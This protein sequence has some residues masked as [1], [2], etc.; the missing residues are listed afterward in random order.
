MIKYVH[1]YISGTT[2]YRNLKLWS[3]RAFLFQKD[4]ATLLIFTGDLVIKAR[5]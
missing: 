4:L 5:F 3:D 1:S 2:N